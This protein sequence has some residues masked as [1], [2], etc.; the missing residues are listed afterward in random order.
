MKLA[1]DAL[2]IVAENGDDVARARAQI[3]VDRFNE[4]REA[5]P[6]DR[7]HVGLRDYGHVPEPEAPAR[8]E[9]A[10]AQPLRT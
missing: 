2:A 5:H 1:L 10:P 3:L 9:P 8:V 4:V 7:N 6:G